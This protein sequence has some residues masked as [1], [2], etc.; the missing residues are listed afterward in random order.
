MLLVARRGSL[1]A[2]RE[3][4]RAW[5]R[6]FAARETQTAGA[7]AAAG[8]AHPCSPVWP[9]RSPASCGPAWPTASTGA[10][11]CQASSRSRAPAPWRSPARDCCEARQQRRPA[12]AA[13]RSR[14]ARCRLQDGWTAG[15]QAV[16]SS[17]R[18]CQHATLLASAESDEPRC[19]GWSWPAPQRQR[20]H[21]AS[22]PG[23][24]PARRGGRAAGAPPSNTIREQSSVSW[25]QHRA[26]WLQ[27]GQQAPAHRWQ[28]Q[29]Q[30]RQRRHL[31]GRKQEGRAQPGHALS[32]LGLHRI[33]A[34]PSTG[35][36]RG[37]PSRPPSPV[38]AQRAES[39]GVCAWPP[40]ARSR[41]SA[42]APWHAELQLKGLEL[43]PPPYHRRC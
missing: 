26:S 18:S 17:Y 24:P 11:S 36:A 23:S 21:G 28:R 1:A 30:R 13:L 29:L 31:A 14:G 34:C 20:Q 39:C 25:G 38:G 2:E 4:R 42:S 10:S 15:Q 37:H 8:L 35:D 12:S 33:A 6:P 43:A 5:L 3:R 32:R 9:A 40:I 22:R 41:S 19:R 7:A 16:C 27:G